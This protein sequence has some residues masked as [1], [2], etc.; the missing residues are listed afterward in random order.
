MHFIVLLHCRLLSL[1][2]Y[3]EFVKTTV[4]LSLFMWIIFA[5]NSVLDICRSNPYFNTLKMLQK[6]VISE[7]SYQL[8]SGVYG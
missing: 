4:T 2:Y 6:L 5:T 1:L 7:K 8:I 3:N